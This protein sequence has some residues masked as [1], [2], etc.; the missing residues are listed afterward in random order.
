MRG[1]LPDGGGGDESLLPV[2]KR[3]EQLASSGVAE[4]ETSS[5]LEGGSQAHQAHGS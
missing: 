1:Q 4:A 5:T 3:T 2:I